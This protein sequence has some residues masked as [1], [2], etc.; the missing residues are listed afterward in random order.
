M[1]HALAA[2][3]LLELA[4]SARA[5]LSFSPDHLELIVGGSAYIT[6]YYAGIGTTGGVFRFDSCDPGV[7]TA[8]GEVVV[9]T[10]SHGGSGAILVT[11]RGP[12]KTDVCIY[13][14][15]VVPVTVTCGVVPPAEAA[16]TRVQA[17]AG[18]PV[19]LSIVFPLLPN[20][21]YTWYR[22]HAGDTSTPLSFGA[23]DLQFTPA[24]AGTHF[25]WVSAATPC[26]SSSVEFVVEARGGRRRAVRK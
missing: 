22:G 4:G 20:T 25:V 11:A 23:D 15:A 14:A 18:V 8:A 13:G 21:T 24:F 1:R 12:G 9:P 3:L 19:T 10:G 6:V 2:L 17:R 26:A 16:N 5:A 7:A